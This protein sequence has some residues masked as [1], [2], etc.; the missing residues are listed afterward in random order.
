[1]TGP[2]V[3]FSDLMDKTTT[4]L[5]TVVL[6][7]LGCSMVFLLVTFRS[8]LLPIKAVLMNL[9]AVTAA[10]GLLTLAT[11]HLPHLVGS[12]VNTLIPLLAFTLVFGLSIDYEIFL[13]HR[14]GEHYH[15]IGDNTAAVVHGLRHTAR[16]ITMAA[17]VMVVTFAACSPRTATTWSSSASRSPSRSPWTPRSSDWLSSRPD[18]HPRHPQLVAPRTAGPP[19]EESSVKPASAV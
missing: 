6:L 3:I 12:Q 15:A 7:V 13:I 16:P 1:M 10:F 14:I 4:Q 18:A 9:L 2:N 5:S 11:R 19:P 17:A 8:I